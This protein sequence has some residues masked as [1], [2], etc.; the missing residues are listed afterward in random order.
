MCKVHCAT[1]FVDYVIVE[2]SVVLT[3]DHLS[4]GYQIQLHA[5]VVASY[6]RR[7]ELLNKSQNCYAPVMYCGHNF[8]TA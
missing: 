3:Y 7:M 4:V 6:P 5:G 2:D 1:K 8:I